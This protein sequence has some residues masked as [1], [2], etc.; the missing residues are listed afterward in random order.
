MTSIPRNRNHRRAHPS[1]IRVDG[2]QSCRITP[3]FFDDQFTE[4]IPLSITRPGV[5]KELPQFAKREALLGCVPRWT[6]AKSAT[7]I[8]SVALDGRGGSLASVQSR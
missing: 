7:L 8:S 4:H 3:P 1:S 2:R 6:S 5:K